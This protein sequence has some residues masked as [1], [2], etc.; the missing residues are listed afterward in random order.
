MP[1]ESPVVYNRYSPTIH[2]GS[3]AASWGYRGN[4]FWTSANTPDLKARGGSSTSIRAASSFLSDFG[5]SN[6]PFNTS[7]GGVI[8][9]VQTAGAKGKD[10]KIVRGYVRRSSPDSSDVISTASL[11]F[12]YNPENIIRDYVSYLDQAALDPFNTLYDSGN[13]VA[14][15]SFV[16]FSFDLIFDRQIETPGQMEDGVLRDYKYFDMVVRNVPPGS[17]SSGVPD[18]GVMMVNPKDITVVFSSELT[19][20]GRPTNARVAFTKFTHKMVPTRM[21][22]SLTMIITYFG[23]LRESFGFDTN[24]DIAEYEALVPYTSIY[25]DNYTESDLEEAQRIWIEEGQREYASGKPTEIPYATQVLNNAIGSAVTQGGGAAGIGNAVG[26][27][28]RL[29]ALSFAKTRVLNSTGYSMPGRM[30]ATTY[31]CSSLVGRSY[32]DA[33]ANHLVNG[34]EE[35]VGTVASIVQYQESTGWTHMSKVPSGSVAAL[36]QNMQPGDLLI[37]SKGHSGS[38]GGGNHIGFFGGF[39]DEGKTRC[40]VVHARN[41]AKGCRIDDFPTSYV[42][43]NYNII[44]RVN[45]AGSLSTGSGFLSS[46]IGNLV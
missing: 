36:Q 1:T 34:K 40:E 10:A 13:L 5:L 19:V 30:G 35:T 44:G 32:Q 6:P 29:R 18:N 46:Q 37:K 21:V 22:V 28:V 27:D 41:S 3:N 43:G 25:D 23:P 38:N 4:G 17:P 8:T 20:Q 33:G 14:P 7:T 42:A 11:N 12:M 2:V 9:P 16:N 26:G 15:P 39:L 31:D 24:H 45:A